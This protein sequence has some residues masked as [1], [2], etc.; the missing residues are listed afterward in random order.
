MEKEGKIQT[1]L[2]LPLV[3]LFKALGHEET[4]A[5]CSEGPNFLLVSPGPLSHSGDSNRASAKGSCPDTDPT[6][7]APQPRTA[8]RRVTRSHS[9]GVQQT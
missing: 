3:N 2:F 5:E 6:G 7:R 4:G 8:D 9:A 1:R